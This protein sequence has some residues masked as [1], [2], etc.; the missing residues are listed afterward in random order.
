[1]AIE[2]L[3]VFHTNDLHSHF[4]NVPKIRRYLQQTRKMLEKAQTSVLAVDLGD[5][6]DRVHPYTEATNG[7]INIELM[8]QIGYDAVTIGNNEGIGN[9]HQQLMDLYRD[10]KFPVIVDNLLDR[11]TGKP[12]KW[13][14]QKKNIYYCK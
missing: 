12:P 4:E 5:A 2:K 8:N 3:V 13:T 14:C 10:A 6:M 11:T 7:K 1:M 9:S